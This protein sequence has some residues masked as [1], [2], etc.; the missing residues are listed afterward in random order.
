MYTFDVFDRSHS[1]KSLTMDKKCA[2]QRR[3]NCCCCRRLLR[4]IASPIGATIVLIAYLIAGAYMFRSLEAPSSS[5]R[6]ANVVQLRNL[7]VH[8]L[9][10]IT[11]QFNILYKESW[12]QMVGKEMAQ[13]QRQLVDAIRQGVTDEQPSWAWQQA[14][15]YSLGLI[16]TLGKRIEARLNLNHFRRPNTLG[17]LRNC[18]WRQNAA[19][20][21]DKPHCPRC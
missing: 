5:Q 12:T 7:T 2:K 20:E 9:W 19:R 21:S 10:N 4:L 6:A 16:T 18:F 3:K 11:E 15:V 13:F 8:K 1:S 17:E 14:F